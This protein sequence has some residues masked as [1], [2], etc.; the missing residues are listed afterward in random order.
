M[1]TPEYQ[2]D[3]L[4]FLVIDIVEEVWK[5][6]RDTKTHRRYDAIFFQVN[7]TNIPSYKQFVRDVSHFHEIQQNLF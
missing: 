3:I 6:R 5:G 1:Y 4:N 7:A 2:S